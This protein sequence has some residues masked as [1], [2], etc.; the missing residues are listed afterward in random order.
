LR[1]LKGH[2][3]KKKLG[4]HNPH[5]KF[6]LHC[7]RY[8]MNGS[9]EATDWRVPRQKIKEEIQSQKEYKDRNLERVKGKSHVHYVVSHCNVGVTEYLFNTSLASW[10]DAW[11]LET[12]TTSHMIFRR[13]F[14][15]DFND[16]VDGV[17]YFVDRSSLKHS[18]MGTIWLKMFGL[19]DFFMHN[20]IYIPE[21]QRNVLSLVHIR[22][23]GHFFH[24]F[25]GKVDKEGF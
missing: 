5:E 6:D 17:V 7:T 21:L 4:W 1:E 25:D 2:G 19:P 14:F 8:R 10:G 12:D 11:L 22:Q 3:N 16:N 24:M 18:G 23:Q 13:Y 9:H 15:K 20:V